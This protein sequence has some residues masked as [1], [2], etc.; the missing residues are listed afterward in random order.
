MTTIDRREHP[1]K[2]FVVSCQG[3]EV[4]IRAKTQ[5]SALRKARRLLKCGAD[6][7]LS[8]VGLSPDQANECEAHGLEYLEESK[9]E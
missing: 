4:L 1:D 7:K 8:A 2:D 3:T 6:K 5:A 9:G